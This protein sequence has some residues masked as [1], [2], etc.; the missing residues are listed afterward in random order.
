MDM[1]RLALGLR[2]LLSLFHTFF[3]L[4]ILFVYLRVSCV[5]Y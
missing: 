4:V 1:V 3:L 5:D 2:V